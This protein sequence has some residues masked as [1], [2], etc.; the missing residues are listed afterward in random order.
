[1]CNTPLS[2]INFFCLLNYCYKGREKNEIK[3]L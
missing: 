3:P 2:V 1:M